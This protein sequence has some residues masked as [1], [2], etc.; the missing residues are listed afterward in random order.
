MTLLLSVFRSVFKRRDVNILLS[1]SF[2]PLIIPALS[3]V[4]EGQ[5]S[6]DVTGSLVNFFASIIETQYQLVLPALVFSLIVSSVFRDEINSGLLFLYKDIKRSTILNAKLLSLYLV[7]VIYLIGTFI[8][9]TVIYFLSIAPQT[10]VAIFPRQDGGQV[11]LQILTVVMIHVILIT[12]VAAVSLKKTSLIGV[13]M[14][15]LFNIVA[16]VVPLLNGFRYTFPN[17]YPNLIDRLS[18]GP[19]FGISVFLG[20][21]YITWAYLSAR[22]QFNKIEY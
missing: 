18:F 3:G 20:V 22:R 8:V 17:T 2:L 9:T 14:G 4:M 19:A 11:F 15:I 21:L 12:L 5:L 16:Q 13:L 6:Q 10:A 1:F 7:Y